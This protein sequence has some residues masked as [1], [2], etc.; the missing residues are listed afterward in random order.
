MKSLFQHCQC[1]QVCNGFPFKG[2]SDCRPIYT[3]TS[4]GFAQADVQVFEGVGE[5]R[6]DFLGVVNVNGSFRFESCFRPLPSFHIVLERASGAN[7]GRHSLMV[8]ANCSKTLTGGAC[9]RHCV[10]L[11]PV[12]LRRKH[13]GV[14]GNQT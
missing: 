6:S 13:V 2:S 8:R 14:K 12:Q 7:S 4:C 11:V 3:C 5:S 10:A 9:M 1:G